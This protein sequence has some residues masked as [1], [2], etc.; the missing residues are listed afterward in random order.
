[1][2]YI[3]EKTDKTLAISL[4]K[5]CRSNLLINA[6]FFSKQIASAFHLLKLEL[7]KMAVL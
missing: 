3:I 2:T 5:K 7:N 1:M 4:L 6:Q